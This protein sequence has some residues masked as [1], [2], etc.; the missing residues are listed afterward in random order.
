M[1]DVD[2]GRFL[3]PGAAGEIVVKG[4][5]V[6][7]GYWRR[8]E[9]TREAIRDGWFH[10]GDIGRAGADGYFFIEDRLK[11]M[12]IV[13]GY[14]VYPAEVERAL[15]R[16]PAVSEA[17]A[18]GVPDPVLGERLR[19]AVTLKPAAAAAASELIAHC[20]ASLAE[21]KVPA[22]IEFVE[23]IPK[24][25]AGKV[26]K[27]VLRD[28]Y[29]ASPAAASPPEGAVKDA[30]ELERR[31]VGWMAAHL[32]LQPREIHFDRPFAEFGLTS[33]AAVQLAEWLGRAV[34]HPVAITIAWRYSTPRTLARHLL[35]G[36]TRDGAK[37]LATL[38]EEVARLSEDQAEALLLAE[39]DAL[40][41][42]S[43]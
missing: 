42:T 30:A 36:A 7:L 18:Y 34:G 6:M 20:R 1:V 24:C 12:A 32:D 26:R 3:P 37:T 23:A 9:E 35:P 27:R 11:D 39:L 13:G 8:P 15:R 21:Y 10:T 17:A 25:R 41:N 14:N 19:A 16:H 22:A 5:N 33:L 31:I 40:P 28:A 29:R 38:A 4:P 2:D 43:V